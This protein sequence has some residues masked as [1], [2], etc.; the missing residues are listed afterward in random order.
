MKDKILLSNNIYRWGPI[1][2]KLVNIAAWKGA[3]VNYPRRF[4]HYVFP[5]AFAMFK[6]RN[7]LVI[8]APEKLYK[9]GSVVFK[10][11]ILS[12]WRKKVYREWQK[13]LTAL[14]TFYR[15]LNKI[16]LSALTDREVMGLWRRYIKVIYNFWVPGIIPELGAYAGELLLK[17]KIDSLPLSEPLRRQALSALST[18]FR[19][20]FYQEEDIDQWRL[21]AHLKHKN[22]KRLLLRHQQKYFWLGNSYYRQ[23]V[24]SIE[25]FL[26]Q[27]RGKAKRQ[28]SSAQAINEIIQHLRQLQKQKRQLLK[29]L[30]AQR[31]FSRISTTLAHCIWWQD[32]RKKY[33]FQYLHYQQ[34]LI[35][36]IAKRAGVRSDLLDMAW[37]EEV[38]IK[39]SLQFKQSLVRRQKG[40]QLVIFDRNKC[41]ISRNDKNV[42]NF[43]QLWAPKHQ[44]G[45]EIK[46]IIVYQTKKLVI[47]QVQ[48]IKTH[49][50]ILKF[51]RGRILVTAMTAPEYIGAIRKARAI[52]TDAGGLT[53][54]AAI[55][56]RELKKPCIVGTKNATKALKNGMKV[57]VNTT[58]GEIK[59]L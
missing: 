7:L 38:K 36:E 4:H 27:I 6:K 19:P 58:I 43:F 25:Y 54:H 24:L 18:V 26:T 31:E 21:A 51:P 41:V 12:S 40:R 52:V 9:T 39:L 50:D 22:F 23:K 47:G 28:T 13:R 17:Q 59:K 46:G 55:V 33:I 53:C 32:Q 48:I 37:L 16:Y 3:F 8:W 42:K 44:A 34:L 11:I 49:K 1:P 10:K 14:T 30:P 56:A 5:K 57:S 20:S 29:K 35:N 45:S 2:A 15:P